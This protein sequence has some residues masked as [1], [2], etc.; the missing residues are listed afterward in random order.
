MWDVASDFRISL[1]QIVEGDHLHWS[2]HVGP[3]RSAVI[4]VPQHFFSLGWSKSTASCSNAIF[5]KPGSK[6]RKASPK[7]A[8]SG[9]AA[10][11]VIVTIQTASLMTKVQLAWTTRS[12]S[13]CRYW[14]S[15]HCGAGG[16]PP[17]G[18]PHLTAAEAG[19]TNI[20]L[21]LVVLAQLLHC[22][23][24]PASYRCTVIGSI[25]TD[26]ST[27]QPSVEKTIYAYFKKVHFRARHASPTTVPKLVFTHPA[28]AY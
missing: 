9:S 6:R 4:T 27:E 22:L 19:V 20:R 13:T 12:F 25:V 24:A 1:T 18:G 26:T 15:L 28:E 5:W 21:R 8:G 3:R 16:P 10:A 17:A 11:T 23:T 14:H 2:P 7:P